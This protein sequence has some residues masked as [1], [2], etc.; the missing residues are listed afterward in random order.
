MPSSGR[1]EHPKSYPPLAIVEGVS[2]DYNL[3]FRVIFGEFVQTYE[4]TRNDMTSRC[5]DAIA[6]EPTGN[7]RGGDAML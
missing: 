3:H 7:L 5:V 4:G 6:L 1:K 2:L